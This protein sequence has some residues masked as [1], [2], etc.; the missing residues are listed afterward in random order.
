[1]V[2]TK[3]PRATDLPRCDIG[4]ERGAFG[5]YRLLLDG[6]Q[7]LTSLSAVLRAQPV[8]L[9]EQIRP[10]K[11][12]TDTATAP[13]IFFKGAPNFGFANG[14]V[15]VSLAAVAKAAGA[16]QHVLYVEFRKDGVPVHPGP[17][18]AVNEGQ[19]VRG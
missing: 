3:A 9:P 15:N 13:Y 16:R 19:K 5:G 7:R 18:W 14:V 6:Q 10:A 12:V 2:R 1:M 17:W 4:Q 11:N 8:E